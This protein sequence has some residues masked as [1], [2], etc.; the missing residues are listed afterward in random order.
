QATEAS[1]ALFQRQVGA[2]C[3][4][5]ASSRDQDGAH[6]D[7]SGLY[8]LVLPEP[9]PTQ[10][11]WSI[12]AYDAKT[13]S[14]VG[15]EQNKAVLSSARDRYDLS[16]NGSLELYFGPEAPPGNTRNWL[17]T[18]LEDGFFLYLRVYGPEAA[19]LD[20]RWRPSDLIR[21]DRRAAPPAAAPS[22]RPPR[23][24]P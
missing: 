22:T 15:T 14:Q 9:V 24:H 7:G 17:Q 12:T 3:I 11:F 10:L 23:A 16:P 18:P 4:C 6:L 1:P 8:K 20:G 13:R 19:C 2:G 5:F 21:L